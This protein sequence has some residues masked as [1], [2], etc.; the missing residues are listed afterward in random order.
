VN[1]RSVEVTVIVLTRDEERNI[2]SCLAS[3]TPAAQVVVVDS[4]STDATKEVVLE[5]GVQVI[6][7]AWLGYARQRNWALEQPAVAHEWVLFVDADERVPQEAWVEIA[8]FLASPTGNAGSFRRSV[9]FLGRELRHGGFESARVVRLLRRGRASYADRPVHEHPI[10]NGKIHRF[11]SRLL[12]NDG[13]AFEAWLARHNQYSSL[14]A[15]ARLKRS[16][17]DQWSPSGRGVRLKEAL[18]RK[19]WPNLP[20]R[21]LLLFLYVY[22]IRVGFLDGLAGLRIAALYGFQELCVQIKSEELTRERGQG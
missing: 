16:S 10:V 15:E 12:H 17:S 7:R 2:G 22:V 21:P 14:E 19:I 9:I 3:L 1:P 4:G 5:H 11:S 20:F 8:E 13:R 18:R 6:D